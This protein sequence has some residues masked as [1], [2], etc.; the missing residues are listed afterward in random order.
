LIFATKAA[1]AKRGLMERAI[2][3]GVAPLGTSFLLPSGSVTWMFWAIES[4]VAQPIST[5]ADDL[6]V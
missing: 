1:S 4:V 3:S 2:S 5:V 6:S